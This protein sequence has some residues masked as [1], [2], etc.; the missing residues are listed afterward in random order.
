MAWPA[1]KSID[2]EAE[3][4]EGAAPPARVVTS[5]ALLCLCCFDEVQ[6]A[7]FWGVRPS[8]GLQDLPPDRML[9]LAK[10]AEG[11]CDLGC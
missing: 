2:V 4:G 1:R 7:A 3:G 9:N 11:C 10:V 6:H 8:P 5:R